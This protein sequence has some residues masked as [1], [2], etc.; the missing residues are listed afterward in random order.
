[1]EI[2]N[3]YARDFHA[4][5][6]SLLCKLSSEYKDMKYSLGNTF[7]M[8][9]NVLNNPVLFSKFLDACYI[10]SSCFDKFLKLTFV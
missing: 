3:E 1:M 9:I 6:E 7:E 8:T 4:S 5:I 10:F 2:L